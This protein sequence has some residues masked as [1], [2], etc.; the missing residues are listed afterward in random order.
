MAFSSILLE[1]HFASALVNESV[2]GAKV[3]S[4]FLLITRRASRSVAWA[5]KCGYV[6]AGEAAKVKV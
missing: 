3:G 6:R 4:E 5:D 2:F 1:V